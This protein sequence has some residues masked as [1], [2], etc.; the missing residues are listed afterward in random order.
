[1]GIVLLGVVGLGVTLLGIVLLGLVLLGLVVFEVDE[2]LDVDG[3]ELD[4]DE[5]EVV[6]VDGLVVPLSEGTVSDEVELSVSVL[7]EEPDGSVSLSGGSSTEVIASDSRTTSSLASIPLLCEEG[8]EFS[9]VPVSTI[10]EEF[11]VS[12]PAF[13]T[14]LRILTSPPMKTSTPQIPITI[15]FMHWFLSRSD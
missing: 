1:M 6:L 14:P 8:N 7:T 11:F 12:S 9:V 2:L 3:A 4:S 13:N 10:K 5:D 15:F